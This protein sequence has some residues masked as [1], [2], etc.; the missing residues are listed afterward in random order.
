MKKYFWIFVALINVSVAFADAWNNAPSNKW[1]AKD[2]LY[3]DTHKV[4]YVVDTATTQEPSPLYRT[5]MS[6]AEA[7]KDTF[8]ISAPPYTRHRVYV[9]IVSQNWAPGI[10]YEYLFANFWSF[11]GRFSY[12]YFTKKNIANY[13]D[14]EGEMKTFS[15]PLMLRWYWGRRNMGTSQVIDAVGKNHEIGQKS[16]VEC[17]LQMR[18]DPVFYS[19]DL[20]SPTD[21][22]RLFPH[23][24]NGVALGLGFGARLIGTRFFWG[25][26]ISFG[27]FVKKPQFMGNIQ[28]NHA[29]KYTHSRLIDN[30]YMDTALSVGFVF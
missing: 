26:E 1:N 25:S 3:V 5:S 20:V 15:F 30:I 22:T 8:G 2:T 19:V 11:V 18:M 16:Q 24:E 10:T 17:F 28:V 9:E 21:K 27:R 29:D 13:T 23:S 7:L 14:V 4:T 12:S 6:E